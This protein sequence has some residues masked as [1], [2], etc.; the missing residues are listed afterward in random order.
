MKEENNT[1]VLPAFFCFKFTMRLQ[2]NVYN[3]GCN[4]SISLSFYQIQ[5]AGGPGAA[6]QA[7]RG[8][9]DPGGRRHIPVLP[10]A[11]MTSVARVRAGGANG[12][13]LI[14]EVWTRGSCTLAYCYQ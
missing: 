7:I 4:I 10:A 12:L 14:V 6:G 5:F 11:S 8:D 9:H 2:Y 1:S 13:G 3:N